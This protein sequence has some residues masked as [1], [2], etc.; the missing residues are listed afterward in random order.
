MPE[1]ATVEFSRGLEGVIAA[2]SV[3]SLVDGE[4]GRLY[5]VGYPIQT[6]AEHSTFEEVCALLWLKRLPKRHELEAID[7]DL[8]AN[9]SIPSE[10]VDLI[11]KFPHTAHPMDAL[12]TA[13]GHLG[14]TD[15][16]TDDSSPEANRRKAIRMTAKIPT[17]IAAFER[18]RAG[19]PFVPPRSD[20]S[21]AG[22]F[23]YMLHGKEPDAEDTHIL[24]VCLILHAEHGMNASTFAAMVT[25]STLADL[26]SAVVT[27]INTL[28]G[29]LHGGA[30]EQVLHML[31]EIGT[32]ANVPGWL[33][34]AF[35]EK[36]KIMGFGHR[37]YK[38]YDPRCSILKQFAHTLSVKRGDMTWY[39]MGELIEKIMIERYAQKR[40]YPNVDF[41]SGIV[42][43]FLGIPIDQFTPIFA[44]A[45]VSGW[46]ARCL[47][48]LEDNR[49]F[50]PLDLYVGEL[51]LPYIPIDA[52]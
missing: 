14:M 29:P 35:A 36:R 52:R 30:N 40:V 2:K 46:T 42:Y 16:E 49:L 39:E 6:L 41:Y 34:K 9:R 5:Y 8:K 50:R 19:K 1:S 17:L 47:E 38:A 26:Y 25:I 3:L 10:L 7:H 11:Y 13:V 24:D 15:P 32:I 44:M 51:D 27:G 22:N 20:L 45:R 43:S 31:K 37:V 4:G 28:K 12:R 48:Y 23:L 21:I 33:E 18:A